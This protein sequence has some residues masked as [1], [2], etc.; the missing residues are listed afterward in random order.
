L[1]YVALVVE[2]AIVLALIAL[3]AS[4]PDDEDY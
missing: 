2:L 1:K 4:E 3:K